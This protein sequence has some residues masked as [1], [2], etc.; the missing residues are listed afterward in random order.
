MADSTI[1]D[2]HDI[3]RRAG[4]LS[5][6]PAI[7]PSTGHLLLAILEGS[8]TAAR[9]LSLRGLSETKVRSGIREA[10]P[11][12]PQ[13]LRE[14][15]DKAAQ[16]ANS[17]GGRSPSSLHI[18]AALATVR[19]CQAH[20]IL[21]DAGLN[22]DVIRNQALRCLTNGFTREHGAPTE[23]PSDA[24]DR[25]RPGHP[26]VSR[27]A[28]PL[29]QQL[30][31][32]PASDRAGASRPLGQPTSPASSESE[33]EP[34]RPIKLR[35]GLGL[36]LEQAQRKL[37]E[38]RIPEPEPLPI[39]PF[40]D[41]AL[42]TTPLEASPI[43]EQQ[44][45]VA[46]EPLPV[47][48][49][50]TTTVFDLSPRDFPLLSNIGR[51]L[52]LEAEA[53]K[54]DGIVGREHETEQMS[55]IL[56]KRRANSPCLIGP[57][58][59]GKTAVVEGLALRVVH[60]EV[61]GL[62]DRVIIEIRPG[63]LLSG[64]SLRGALSER[65]AEMRAEVS[66]ARGQVI[67]FFDEFHSLLASNDGAEAIQELKEALGRGELPCI[68]ATTRTEYTRQI[69]A[70]P[71][72]ARR[73]TTVEVAEP[74]EDEAVAILA[75]LEPLYSD[76]HQV[77][78]APDSLSAAVQLSTRYVPDRALPD[79]ALALLDLAG[80]RAR[81]R[82]ATD[83]FRSDVAQVLAEQIG[84]PTER[85]TIGDR[86]RL[87]EIEGDLGQRVVGHHH[88]LAALGETLRRNAAGF[89]TGR[90]IGSFLF[91]GPTGVGK[92]ETAKALADLLFP[93]DNSMVRLDMTEFSEAHA[94][95]RLVGAPPGYVGHEDGGQ[96]TE[97]VRRRPYCLVLLDEIEK[98]HRE[99]IQ[100]LL[101]V[102]DDGR[103][104][105]SKGRTVVLENA[106]IVMTSNLGADMRQI[107]MRKK[108]VG[109]GAGPSEPEPSDVT[110]AI[111][112]SAR[113]ALPA[114]L[115]NRIDEPLVFAP[116]NREQISSIAEMMIARV[117]T[118]LHKE[119]GITL[120][121]A[122]EAIEALLDAGGY[123]SEL[124]AR[125]MRRTIQRLIE[126]PI[127]KLVLADELP[128]AA[129]VTIGVGD[130]GQ[131]RFDVGDTPDSTGSAP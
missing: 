60:G 9:T 105:D 97:A 13:A 66:A 43:E 5:A 126:G 35:R 48:V 36:N 49:P 87:L 82:G 34:S 62:E 11:E 27:D 123:D 3:K 114:E 33:L 70:D 4:E 81:R 16:Y 127:A 101:Q 53:G 128:D 116:L 86:E 69:E 76:H 31:I 24:N 8:S 94:V 25:L 58:G 104:T 14:V 107:G 39:Q 91:L 64:T 65:L 44:L 108:K 56:N 72:L 10:G 77:S 106:V 93:G 15:E 63:D 37:R 84:V 38:K 59:V 89:R 83:V 21:K 122:P 12:S 125:P 121:A 47:R 109:F 1:G 129:V 95:A 75:G 100:I 117:S 7:P 120:D 103:L 71:A 110:D 32:P 112:E 18:L 45:I 61:L 96:L 88:V 111:L 30:H 67:L 115:W 74:S 20:Q 26:F 17:L 19:E 119:H 2:I 92:T 51:N 124:G 42:E 46:P 28:L 68:A 131:L 73:F 29:P 52:T 23:E 41:Q 102:L 90:P 79:K 118:Q 54:L 22:T 6:D 78:F 98:A 85:L 40:D 57:P 99:V 130:D 55:D 113:G 50:E 80:A